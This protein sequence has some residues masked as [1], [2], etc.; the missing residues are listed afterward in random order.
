MFDGDTCDLT[1][2]PREVEVR[3][4]CELARQHSYISEVIE[5]STCKYIIILQTPLICG[6]TEF[7]SKA[8]LLREAVKCT[9]NTQAHSQNAPLDRATSKDL[10]DLIDFRRKLWLQKLKSIVKSSDGNYPLIKMVLSRLT[11]MQP[12]PQ[13]GFLQ[14]RSFNFLKWMQM[15]GLDVDKLLLSAENEQGQFKNNTDNSENEEQKKRQ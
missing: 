15:M 10:H 6:F 2:A 14:Q 4:Y 13:A 5:I 9:P 3:Y 12:S 11:E 8:R 1:N 7:N